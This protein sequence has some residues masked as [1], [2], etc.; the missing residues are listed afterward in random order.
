L[1]AGCI[2][3]NIPTDTEL[4]LC[5]ACH[6]ALPKLKNACEQC[7]YP[8]DPWIEHPYCG[9]CSLKPE[10]G[11]TTHIPFHYRGI[12]S[13]LLTQLKFHGHVLNGHIVGQLM[14]LWLRQHHTTFP[15]K[16]VPVPLHWRRLLTRGFNQAAELAKPVSGQ[17]TL[18][19]DR[20]NCRRV[21]HTT[22]QSQLSKSARAANVKHAFQVVD[23]VNGLDVALVDDIYT[24]G[25]TTHTLAHKLR[26]HG[27]SH[28]RIWCAARAVLE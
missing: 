7:A 13:H 28:V 17:L 8:L 12:I 27:A 5:V 14:A 4:A 20:F 22:S 24:T 9:A 18:P 6:N 3:C 15:D 26:Q 25:H 1:P 10:F 2:I 21:H 11:I 23:K 16:I 19:F